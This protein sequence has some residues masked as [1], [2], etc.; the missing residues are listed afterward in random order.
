MCCCFSSCSVSFFLIL[1]KEKRQERQ[2][3]C[4][5]AVTHIMYSFVSWHKQWTVSDLTP[6]TTL[7]M[8]LSRP[9]QRFRVYAGFTKGHASV[10]PLKLNA[11]Q[12]LSR[13]D[14][15]RA[16]NWKFVLSFGRIRKSAFDIS[17]PHLAIILSGISL[18]GSRQVKAREFQPPQGRFLHQAPD[19]SNRLRQL[20]DERSESSRFIV[21]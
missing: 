14:K 6:P 20:V 19:C 17:R 21:L 16:E 5:H 3:R 12:N 8:H 4:I 10:E 1:Q 9:S 7:E 15:G 18:G 13:E 11:T 2:P